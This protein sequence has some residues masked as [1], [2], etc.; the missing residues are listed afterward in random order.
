METKLVQAVMDLEIA[1][2]ELKNENISEQ[3]FVDNIKKVLLD[4]EIPEP[5]V[6]I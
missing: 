2:A 3:N 6:E 1:I 4:L 5:S